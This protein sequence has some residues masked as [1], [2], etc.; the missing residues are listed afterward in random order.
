MTLTNISLGQYISGKIRKGVTDG[1]LIDYNS[2][3][4]ISQFT[5]FIYPDA[6]LITEL[7]KDKNNFPRIS[8]ESMPKSTVEEMGMEDESHLEMGNLKITV[9]CVR[10]LICT[11]KSTTD[12]TIVFDVAE[13]TYALINLP[14]SEIVAVTDDVPTT[15]IRGIDYELIDDD[16]DGFYD[17]IKWLGVDEPADTADFYVDYKRYAT[18]AELAR[19]IAQDVNAYLRT[20]RDWSE[21]IVWSYRLISS[22]PIPFDERIGIS[23]Y[24]MVVQFNGINIGETV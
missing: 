5:D 2:T 11:I 9:W 18:G 10:N 13:D 23:R 3:Y 14:T 7:L 4:R 15:F 21:N 20:W 6:P 1:D 8:V 19:I 12:E 24:E 16:N 17:S 22:V